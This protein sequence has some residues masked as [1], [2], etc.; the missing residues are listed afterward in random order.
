MEKI[1]F[2]PLR[3]FQTIK[4]ICFEQRAPAIMLLHVPVLVLGKVQAPMV[5]SKPSV[6]AV[7]LQ[8]DL[9]TEGVSALQLCKRCS[10]RSAINPFPPEEAP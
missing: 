8:K 10:G 1:A 6:P 5:M 7:H 4:E 9:L 2:E 3:I